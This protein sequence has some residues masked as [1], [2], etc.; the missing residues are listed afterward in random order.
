MATFFD[1]CPDFTLTA[2]NGTWTDLDLSTSVPANSLAILRVALVG[3]TA[4]VGFRQKGSTDGNGGNKWNTISLYVNVGSSIYQQAQFL[5]PVDSSG[6]CQYYA[7]N[8]GQSN[9]Y[10]AKIEGYLSQSE[11]GWFTNAIDKTPQTLNQWM[12]VNNTE[13]PDGSAF[14]IYMPYYPSGYAVCRASGSS[15]TYTPPCYIQQC[16]QIV[17]LNQSKQCEAYKAILST[18]GLS[19][20]GY[21]N[22]GLGLTNH[23]DKS[24]DHDGNYHTIDVSSGAPSDATAALILVTDLYNSVSH[25]QNIRKTTNSDDLFYNQDCWNGTWIVGIDNNKQLS[26]KVTSAGY[27]QQA[28]YLQGWTTPPPL[29]ADFSGTPTS[30]NAPLSVDFTDLTND[31]PTSW[32]WDFGDGGSLGLSA[33]ISDSVIVGGGSSY[34]PWTNQNNILLKDGVCSSVTIPAGVNSLS[35]DLCVKNFGFV[36]ASDPTGLTVQVSG[37]ASAQRTGLNTNAYLAWSPDGGTTWYG[38]GILDIPTSSSTVNVTVYADPFFPLPTKDQINSPNFAIGLVVAG[39]ESNS[40]TYNIDS[41]QVSPVGSLSTNTEQNPT[42]VYTKAGTYSVKLTATSVSGSNTTTKINY[43]IVTSKSGKPTAS[44]IYSPFPATGTSPTTINFTDTSTGTPTSWLWNFGDG[45]TST[46][47]NPSH[48]YSSAGNYTVT[49]TSINAYGSDTITQMSIVNIYSPGTASFHFPR[50]ILQG[51]GG[52]SG[53]PGGIGNNYTIRLPLIRVSG[54]AIRTSND[55]EIRIPLIQIS[56]SGLVGNVASGILQIPLLKIIGTT[57]IPSTG[58][59]RIPLAEVYGEASGGSVGISNMVFPLIKIYGVGSGINIGTAEI[60]IPLPHLSGTGLVGGVGHG[61]FVL[62]KIQVSGN[63]YIYYNN[64]GVG[65]ITLKLIKI[66]GYGI[67]IP[68][69]TYQTYV[70]NTKNAMVSSYDKYNFNSFCEF[71]GMY[72]GAGPTGI[73]KLNGESDSGVNVD[74]LIQTGLLNMS[75]QKVKRVT[76]GFIRMRSHGNYELHLITDDRIEYTYPFFS[77]SPAMLPLE[78]K[79][80]RGARGEYWTVKFV[81]VNGEDFEIE[82]MELD[83]EIQSRKR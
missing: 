18:H 37:F 41:I 42:Y 45:G 65:F 3:S 79:T 47:Q 70:L 17:P 5:V 73:H 78:V 35:N 56:A 27:Q 51:G 22:Y 14:A 44:F 48:Q 68:P 19:L 50:I 36:L 15:D 12:I 64:I 83:L 24:V 11:F 58:A 61:S 4:Q 76:H 13:V 21:L 20:A 55:S 80:G 40:I 52:W 32:L 30:G 81:N 2:W 82:N 29:E 74:A 72:L 38:I 69:D 66:E 33:F 60:I 23:V 39:D 7:S 8:A 75:T 54:Y 10:V 34:T 1:V 57:P 67:I 9:T 26:G 43:I 77:T 63:A 62:P 46:N 16:Y 28:F 71:H 25:Q 49:L 6:I 53:S 31:T 59:F